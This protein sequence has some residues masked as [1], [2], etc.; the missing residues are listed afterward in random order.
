MILPFD[1]WTWTL[2]VMVGAQVPR[3]PALPGRLHRLTDDG[4][5][6]PSAPDELRELSAADV[7]AIVGCTRQGAYQRL[8]A[9]ELSGDWGA[10]LAPK[11][12]SKTRTADAGQAERDPIKAGPKDSNESAFQTTRRNAGG[13]DDG[14]RRNGDGQAARNLQRR[15]AQFG[16]SHA[17]QAP[18]E[19]C[20][21][22]GCEGAAMIERTV[23]PRA[24]LA[25]LKAE[26][27]EVETRLQR[28]LDTLAGPIAADNG[29]RRG[30][31]E[32]ERALLR[33]EIEALNRRIFAVAEMCQILYPSPAASGQAV[34]ES[35]LAGTKDHQ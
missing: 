2:N 30:Q 5:E 35:Q 28:V 8:R 24:D 33:T 23:D 21:A 14:S 1:R 12:S 17:A 32:H 26:R 11:R 13:S 25:A 9:A 18:D 4:P 15:P 20:I 19:P 31:L 7:A 34:D 10:L 27:V 3:L 6:I 22:A 29:I 16:N